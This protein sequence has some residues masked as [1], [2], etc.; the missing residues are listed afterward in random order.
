MKA[1]RIDDGHF[2]V[3]MSKDQIKGLGDSIDL[4]PILVGVK[5]VEFKS[6]P[7]E[8]FDAESAEFKDISTRALKKGSGCQAGPR[9][10]VFERTTKEF[11]ELFCGNK[12]EQR[13]AANIITYLPV[14]QE[15]IDADPPQT[16]E[17]EV[18][19]YPKPFT[20]SSR[21]AENAEGTWFAPKTED[22]LTPF[23]GL[24]TEEQLIAAIALFENTGDGSEEVK[25]EDAPKRR[26]R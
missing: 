10:L 20:F 5:A 18:R 12:S 11:Y 6:P 25:T 4:L 15:M 22:C 24:F 2:G 19:T 13:E 26:S 14:T 9:F 17:T 3:Y 7:I 21:L 1:K 23:D 8:S 16:K